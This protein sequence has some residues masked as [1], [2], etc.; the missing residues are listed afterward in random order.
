MKVSDS[1]LSE[2]Y[3]TSLWHKN[4]SLGL[5]GNKARIADS[6]EALIL[7]FWVEKDLNLEILIGPLISKLDPNRLQH[8][9]EEHKSAVNSFQSL[10]DSL[11]QIY[12]KSS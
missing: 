9:R 11:F 5:T 2:A 8:P 12:F 3:K 10:L 4:N 6:V 1:I 7:F